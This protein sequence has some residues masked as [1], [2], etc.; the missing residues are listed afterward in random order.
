MSS[1]FGI[2]G[3]N[4]YEIEGNAPITEFINTL[5]DQ[6][7]NVTY[8]STCN[9]RKINIRLVGVEGNTKSNKDYYK[10]V[11]DY[12]KEMEIESM[13]SINDRYKIM[14]DFVFM[15]RNGNV[16]DEGVRMYRLNS[17]DVG[18]INKLDNND[19]LTYRRAK[20]FRM[21]LPF[22]YDATP[23]FGIRKESPSAAY[24]FKINSIKVMADVYLPSNTA[25]TFMMNL[26]SPLI[27]KTLSRKSQTIKTLSENMEEIYDSSKNS[28]S[29]NR[30]E[31]NRFPR[32][33]LIDLE[34]VM[35]N[36]FEVNSDETI[37]AILAE[38]KNNDIPPVN[39]D[40]PGGN[41]DHHH[42][43]DHNHHHH[44]HHGCE[45]DC[46]EYNAKWKRYDESD[47]MKYLVVPADILDEELD[48]TCMVKVNDPKLQ[49][50]IPD[51]EVGEYVYYKEYINWC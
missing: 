5:P 29:F 45:P 14:V 42:H 23:S 34:L 39:P 48:E 26:H 27:D 46:G 33:I 30:L 8:D 16:I 13:K 18:I 40:N 15:D 22:R 38:N 7:C 49:K 44:H 3:V 25:D 2:F 17:C 31:F 9:S 20:V 43:H 12:I 50:D 4:L 47:P 10:E 35:N 51:I 21:R 36:F 11:Q 37:K 19:E 24:Y 6:S 28:V 1:V 32:E 41:D